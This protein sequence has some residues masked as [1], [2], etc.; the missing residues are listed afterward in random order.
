MGRQ[1]GIQ[2]FESGKLSSGFRCVYT[3]ANWFVGDENNL[4]Q[5]VHS[6]SERLRIHQTVS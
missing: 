4:L 2:E 5:K 1:P 6:R 3:M